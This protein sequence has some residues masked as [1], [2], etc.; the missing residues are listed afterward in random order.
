M[1]IHPIMMVVAQMNFQVLWKDHHVLNEG[2]VG[3]GIH[4]ELLKEMSNIMR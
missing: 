2:K 1:K 4:R 3:H